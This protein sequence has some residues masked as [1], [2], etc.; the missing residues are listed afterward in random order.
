MSPKYRFFNRFKL[1]I[2]AIKVDI[3][4]HYSHFLERGAHHHHGIA[5]LKEKRWVSL[6]WVLTW[7]VPKPKCWF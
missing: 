3:A 4:L 7:A 1:I 6:T 5:L 2:V